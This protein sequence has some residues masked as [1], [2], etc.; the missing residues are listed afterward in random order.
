VVATATVSQSAGHAHD[1]TARPV[2]QLARSTA[3][4]KLRYLEAAAASGV[5]LHTTNEVGDETLS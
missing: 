3:V 5:S 1:A 4:G 2:Y